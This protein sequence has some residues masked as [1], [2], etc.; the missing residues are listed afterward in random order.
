MALLHRLKLEHKF[1]IL[2]LIAF[3]MVA[4]P[5]S[6][7]LLKSFQQSAVAQ[8]EAR[9][10]PP[11]VALN[12]VIQ[13][14]QTHRGISAAMLNG[15]AELEARRPGVR[16]ALTQA[17]DALTDTMKQANTSA[18][19][20]NQWHESHE[21]WQLTERK[22]AN[23]E[24][25]AAESTLLHTRIVNAALLQGDELMAEF[26]LSTDPDADTYFLV[27]AVL[28]N[29]PKLSESMGIMRAIGSSALSQGSLSAEGKATLRA[30]KNQALDSKGDMAR[31]LRRATSSNAEFDTAMTERFNQATVSANTALAMA[32]SALRSMACLTSTKWQC[33]N[34]T[35]RSCSA[36][37]PKSA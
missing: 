19:L 6:A 15:N 4:V 23:K 18:K 5:S 34:W 35:M 25:T 33:N 29:M 22:V 7:Y 17:M 20:Q 37:T 9:G 26:G 8:L 30:L 14:T 10:G 24:I 27:Q 28:V 1:L 36:P 21:Q 31:N 2:G 32:D 16:D 13:L 11:L 12:K 3:V